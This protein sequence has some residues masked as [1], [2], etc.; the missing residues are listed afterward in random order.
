MTSAELLR[1]VGAMTERPWRESPP[2]SGLLVADCNHPEGPVEIA[3][4]LEEAM[5]GDAAAIAALANHATALVALVE[6]CERLR[7]WRDSARSGAVLDAR[8]DDV[9]SAL[10]AVHAV[11][12]EP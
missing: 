8:M 4:I 12:G 11:R 5:L 3:N 9:M 6:A 10:A 2:D 7:K 1:I